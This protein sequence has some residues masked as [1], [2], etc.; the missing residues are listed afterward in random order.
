MAIPRY[1][2]IMLPFLKLFEDR[3]EH[4]F[5]RVVTI[6]AKEFQLT[7]KEQKERYPYYKQRRIFS[8]QVR[9]ARM[10]LKETGL[11]ESTRRGYLKIT[12]R[13]LDVLRQSPPEINLSF[14][15]QYMTGK[16]LSASSQLFKPPIYNLLFLCSK[17]GNGDFIIPPNPKPDDII[18]C[19]NCNS[20]ASYKVIQAQIDKHVKRQDKRL[21]KDL[22]ENLFA[23]HATKT[24][25]NK[26]A[27]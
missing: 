19:N 1:D 6:L 20:S 9:E 23:S 2:T 8:T 14:L 17:C 11:V 13:G 24:T 27:K 21:F 15:D 22:F 5:C 25:K 16:R 7:E 18:V 26:N 12:N 10:H 3:E 4:S